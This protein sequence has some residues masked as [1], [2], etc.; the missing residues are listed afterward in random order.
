MK[1]SN[2][3]FLLSLLSSTAV[4]A[5]QAPIVSDGS[6]QLC[7]ISSNDIGSHE[8]LKKASLFH[9][10]LASASR[11]RV[12]TCWIL[13]S[14]AKAKEAHLLVAIDATQTTLVIK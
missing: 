3:V 1:V 10:V 14:D 4:Q 6:Q 9:A 13:D 5:H 7:Y 2:T 8:W 12:D 11:E